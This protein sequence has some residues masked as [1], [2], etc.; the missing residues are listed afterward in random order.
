MEGEMAA[1][2]IVSH[3]QRGR[4]VDGRDR[5]AVK[6]RTLRCYPAERRGCVLSP[7]YPGQNTVDRIHA[8]RAGTCGLDVA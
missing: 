7:V 5:D 6:W 2:R 3:A 1:K 4:A 8:G